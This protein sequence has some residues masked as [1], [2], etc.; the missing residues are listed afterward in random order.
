M[1][2]I[3]IH[4]EKEIEKIKIKNK[5]CSL[6]KTFKGGRMVTELNYSKHH[7]VQRLHEAGDRNTKDSALIYNWIRQNVITHK[8]FYVLLEYIK[9][10]ERQKVFVN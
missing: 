3:N 6:I 7:A 9:E 2:K 8:D 1:E 10:K 4:L 5:N